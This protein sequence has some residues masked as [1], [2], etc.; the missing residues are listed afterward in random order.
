MASP[1][2]L[3]TNR[4]NPRSVGEVLTSQ[5]LDEL[6]VAL[7]TLLKVDGAAGLAARES[8]LKWLTLNNIELRVGD[9]GL[10][11]GHD[12]DEGSENGGELHFD[13]V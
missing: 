7:G 10:D 8:K 3:V 4:N 6:E 12:G 13:G 2:L 1:G 9:L 5:L 11:G